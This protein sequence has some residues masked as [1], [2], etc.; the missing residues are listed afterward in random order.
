MVE[1][2]IDLWAGSRMIEV[3]WTILGEETLGCSVVSDESNP[4][5][6][7]VPITPI[8]NTQLD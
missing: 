8:M 5:N 3:S 7:I 6:R 4:W 2:A 1:N